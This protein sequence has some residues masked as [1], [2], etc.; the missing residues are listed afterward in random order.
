MI[1][2][3]AFV[4]LENSEFAVAATAS[5]HFGRFDVSVWRQFGGKVPDLR[6]SSPADFDGSWAQ[7]PTKVSGRVFRLPLSANPARLSG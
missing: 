4:G 3:R 1:R 5:T 2:M 7:Q 6:T